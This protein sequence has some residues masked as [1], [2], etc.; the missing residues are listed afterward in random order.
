MSWLAVLVSILL[1]TDINR[2][3]TGALSGCSRH[4]VLTI[5]E[6]HTNMSLTEWRFISIKLKTLLKPEFIVELNYGSL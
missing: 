6:A 2:S 1:T 5:C 4:I 3:K